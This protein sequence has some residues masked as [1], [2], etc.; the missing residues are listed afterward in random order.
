[1]GAKQSIKNPKDRERTSVRTEEP[2]ELRPEISKTDV[3]YNEETTIIRVQPPC[4]RPKLPYYLNKI[5]K[6]SESPLEIDRLSMERLYNG[7]YLKQNKKKYWIDRTN[8]ANCFMLYAKDLSITWVEDNRYWNWVEI[9]ETSDE[10]ILA[11]ELKSVRWLEVCGR[12]DTE[13]LTPEKLYEVV[14]VVKI[15][16]YADGLESITL[17]LIIPNKSSKDVTVNLMNVT[18]RE[19]WIEVPVGRPEYIH[20]HPQRV[21]LRE[22]GSGLSQDQDLQ[23]NQELSNAS[24]QGHHSDAAVLNEEPRKIMPQS[25]KSTKTNK[26]MEAARVLRFPHNYEEILKE[27]DSSVDRSSMDKLYDQLYTGVFLNQKRKKY[28]VDKKSYGNC[29]MLYA[30]DLLITWAENNRFWHWPLV[31]ESS[32][33]L[34]PAAELLDVCWLEIHGRFN[35]TKLSPGLIYEVVFIVMLKDPAYG[36]ENPVNLRLILPDG[37]RQ[38]HTENMVEKRREK[39]IEIPAGEFMTSADQKNGEIEFS[40][41]E[42]EGGNWKKGLVIKC[43]VLRPKA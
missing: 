2:S 25:I 5:L 18:A 36:W 16:E 4:I 28:W 27:A 11:A 1:M 40:L 34:L 10:K 6:E 33:V 43:A 30:R 29:F 19:Q 15:K 26:T 7:V 17:R 31:Q 12:F 3:N 21:L 35:T 20:Q 39:W 14:F 38:G 8:N 9:K 32:D 24:P 42:Y 22:M 41:Y 23:Q 13:A 37:S